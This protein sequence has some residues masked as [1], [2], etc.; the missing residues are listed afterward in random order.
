M[1]STQQ[2]QQQ[3]QQQQP[4]DISEKNYSHKER[5]QLW[6]TSSAR[7]TTHCWMSLVLILV[8]TQAVNHSSN[9]GY[10]MLYEV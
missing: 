2:Q 1:S 8:T 4:W 7:L 9:I 6:G 3:Q 5:E 10:S